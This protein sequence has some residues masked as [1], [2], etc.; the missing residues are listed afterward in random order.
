LDEAARKADPTSAYAHDVRKGRIVAGELVGLAAE[1]HER[2][3]ADGGRR[4]IHWRP[5][6]ATDALGFFPATLSITAG[7]KAGLPFDLLGWQVFTVGSLFGW[8]RSDN[9]RRFRTAYVETGKGQAKSPLMAGIGLYLMG[10]S[11]I[12]RAEVYA[13]AGDKDQAS[14]ALKDAVAMC[15]ATIPGREEGETLESLGHAVVRG[16]GTLAWRIEHPVL[17]GFM[18]ALASTDAISG[19]RPTLVMA[20]EIHEFRS[21]H[22]LEMWSA[23]IAK[24]AGDPL[25][26]LGTNT[27]AADQ[28]VGTEQS[29]FYQNVARGTFQDDTSFAYIAR[30]DPGDK[31]LEDESCWIKALPA[32]DVTYPRENVRGEVAKAKG[33]ASK[34]QSLLR[35]FFGVPVGSSSY[36]IDEGL[37]DSC[38]GGVDADELRGLPCWLGMDPSQ[39]NDL[40]ALGAVWRKLDG[41]F[42]A[43]VSYWKPRDGLADAEVADKAPY[44]QWAES[45]LLNVVPGRTIDLGFVVNEVRDLRAEHDVRALAFDLAHFRG[46]RDAADETGFATWEY[47]GPKEP[48]GSGLMMVRHAQGAKGMHSEKQLWMPRSVQALEDL[49]LSGGITIDA[50]P[51]T[52]WCAGNAKLE[53]DAQGN[54]FFDKKRSRGR[55]DGM[56]A[57]AM[58]VGAAMT[59]TTPAPTRSRYDDEATRDMAF[60]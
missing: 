50:N 52:K 26:M 46:F 13:I 3:Q 36:W 27:P 18:Q 7:A 38:L 23:A 16:T 43:R 15:R 37:W 5:E 10:F 51:L 29:E 14:I 2:D 54:R 25:M 19:P 30:T 33:L 28:V 60:V 20:D 12:Q 11:Q 31:P 39:R 17:G 59:M 56:T 55:I 22:P 35:L 6:M 21:A 24:M 41:S 53:P 45:G 9:L 34:R 58:A 4:G 1:R 47:Q 8:R 48:A 49:I 42:V 32:L 57:L 40:T 44:R